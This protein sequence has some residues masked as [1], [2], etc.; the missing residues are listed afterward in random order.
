MDKS[1]PPDVSPVSYLEPDQGFYDDLI[2]EIHLLTGVSPSKLYSWRKHHD[3]FRFTK[4]NRNLFIN[5]MLKLSSK[6]RVSGHF[7]KLGSR[8]NNLLIRIRGIHLVLNRP[9][10]YTGCKNFL[11]VLAF[12]YCTELICPFIFELNQGNLEKIRISN[13][14]A[15][16]IFT[17]V[18]Q[19]VRLPVSKF[20][21]TNNIFDNS[22]EFI[23]D[24]KKIKY[25]R[26]DIKIKIKKE[27]SLKSIQIKNPKS[28]RQNISKFFSDIES[29]QFHKISAP[30]IAKGNR[31]FT[32]DHSF[33]VNKLIEE[34]E[35]VSTSVRREK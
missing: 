15:C 13:K 34:T 35:E 23:E 4:A 5:S 7:S 19:I 28:T 16:E 17:Y 30:K 22:E 1:V 14:T 33:T 3:L 6:D 31:A 8:P 9:H 18:S 26:N 32:K 10:S 27:N 29:T 25:C 11:V 24:L 2:K 12:E 21:I 20:E